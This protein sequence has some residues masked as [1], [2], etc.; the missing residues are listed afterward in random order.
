MWDF[1]HTENGNFQLILKSI[2]YCEAQA[3][4]AQ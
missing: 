1:L 3:F 4:E 2:H